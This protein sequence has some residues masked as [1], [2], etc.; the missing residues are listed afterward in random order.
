MIISIGVSDY[1]VDVRSF[2]PSRESGI[3]WK[4][5]GSYYRPID[6]GSNTDHVSSQ[7]TICGVPDYIGSV[8]D[9]MIENAKDGLGFVISTEIDEAIFG[10]EYHYGYLDTSYTWDCIL[11]GD[12]DYKIDSGKTAFIAEFTFTAIMNADYISRMDGSA[13]NVDTGF[14]YKPLIPQSITRNHGKAI[15]TIQNEVLQDGVSFKNEQPL[16]TVEYKVKAYRTTS[17]DSPASDAK[18]SLIKMRGTA[19]HIPRANQFCFLFDESGDD[20]Y[21]YLLDLQESAQSNF[22]GYITLSAT[23]GKA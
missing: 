10:S 2:A 12:S 21:V 18:G 6:R 22:N 19:F 7:I 11:D 1:A 16:A 8:R 13:F 14:Q 3:E 5:V 17:G 15:A 23:Y 4:S 9:A 20:D